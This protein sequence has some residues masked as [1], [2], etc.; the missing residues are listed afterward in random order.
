[1]TAQ[2]VSVLPGRYAF[3]LKRIFA[4]ACASELI[5]VIARGFLYRA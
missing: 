3:L 4:F 5:G 1:M 2:T